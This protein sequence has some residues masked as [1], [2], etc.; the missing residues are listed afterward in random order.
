MNIYYYIYHWNDIEEM[1]FRVD[2]YSGK[3]NLFFK[4]FKAF[5]F[6]GFNYPKVVYREKYLFSI[7]K[8][9]ESEKYKLIKWFRRDE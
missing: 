3:Y 5:H 8:L 9:N 1:E 2:S 7:K 6:E 4:L